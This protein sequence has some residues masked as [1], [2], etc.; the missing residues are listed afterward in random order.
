M[1]GRGTDDRH[2]DEVKFEFISKYGEHDILLTL[3]EVFKESE[4]SATLLDRKQLKETQLSVNH[5]YTVI[6]NL[7]A[8]KDFSWPDMKPPDAVVI[9]NLKRIYKQQ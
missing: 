1:A 7:P 2:D 4:A 9:K 6:M 3:K 8:G 5:L